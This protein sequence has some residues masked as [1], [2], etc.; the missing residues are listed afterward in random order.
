M[1]IS[2]RSW[3]VGALVQSVVAAALD[4]RGQ[5]PDVSE[6]DRLVIRLPEK[7]YRMHAEMTW[8]DGF[9][10]RLST[11]Y[12]SAVVLLDGDCG[13]DQFSDARLHSD[14]TNS[15]ARDRVSVEMDPSAADG[16]ASMEAN[17]RDGRVVR[18]ATDSPPGHPGSPLSRDQ[19]M[20]KWEAATVD[21]PLAMSADVLAKRLQGLVEESD[22]AAVLNGLR[23]A[24]GPG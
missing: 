10:S 15:F 16:S 18:A 24:A 9:S 23:G 5:I 8:H 6:I 11:R 13:L 19:V 7:A 12:I 3:P 2:L 20:Q 22:V 21:R 14:D 4:V 1:D 17:L